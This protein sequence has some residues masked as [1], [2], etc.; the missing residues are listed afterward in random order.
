MSEQKY[1]E[2]REGDPLTVGHAGW[3]IHLWFDDEEDLRAFD[4]REVHL[5]CIAW[6]RD[7]ERLWLLV[8]NDAGDFEWDHLVEYLTD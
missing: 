5:G 4:H 6:Q 3:T 8:V 7:E 1:K 2:P